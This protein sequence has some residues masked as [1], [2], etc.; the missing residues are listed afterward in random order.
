MYGPHLIMEAY[1]CPAANLDKMDYIYRV[2][3]DY[4]SL[5]NM[6][7]IMPPHVQ[8]YLDPGNSIWGI[9]GFVMI[10]ESHISIHTYPEKGFFVMDIFSCKEFNVE[11]AVALAVEK[12]MPVDHSY[13]VMH[14]GEHYPLDIQESA[15]IVTDDRFR[16]QKLAVTPG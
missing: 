3:D 6:T 13:R 4:P 5:I 9:S 12:F 14:R 16:F 11:L 7:K 1:G 15:D 10:A 8:K 2:L